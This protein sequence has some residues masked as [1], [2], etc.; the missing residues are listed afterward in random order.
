MMSEYQ[1]IYKKKN[2]EYGE[3]FYY[4]VWCYKFDD[5][6]GVFRDNFSKDEWEIVEVAKIFH[7]DFKKY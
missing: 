7:K 2:D 3:W 5:A 4:Y 1:I 6:I